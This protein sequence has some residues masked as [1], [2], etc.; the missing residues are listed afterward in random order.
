MAPLPFHYYSEA[1]PTQIGYC[2]EFHAEAPKATASEGLAHDAY[3]GAR[4]GLELAT[5]RTKGDEYTYEPPTPK[6]V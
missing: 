4:V 2:V 1:L 3:V 5:L 6:S